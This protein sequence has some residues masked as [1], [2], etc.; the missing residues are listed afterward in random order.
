MQSDPVCCTGK[1]GR[2]SH[3]CKQRVQLPWDLWWPVE[4][5][6]ER[7]GEG[8]ALLLLDR[9]VT[10]RR[11]THDQAYQ[12]TADLLETLDLTKSAVSLLLHSPF[13][14]SGLD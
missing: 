7:M 6:S 1:R 2:L 9:E 13:D 10:H 12:V 8:V 14:T 3:L 4:G 5:W 11:W